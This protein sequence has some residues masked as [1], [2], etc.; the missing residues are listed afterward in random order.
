MFRRQTFIALAFSTGIATAILSPISVEA[1]SA[2]NSQKETAKELFTAGM[3]HY[4]AGDYKAARTSLRLVDGLQLPRKE[5]LVYYQTLE[6]VERQLLKPASKPAVTKAAPKPKKVTRKIVTK[7]TVVAKKATPKKVAPKK[8]PVRVVAPAP[9][10][11]NTR[12]II[13]HAKK[14]RVQEL[15]AEAAML[16]GKGENAAA[17]SRYKQVLTLD[18]KNKTAINMIAEIETEITDASES[19]I[20]V[21]KRNQSVQRG[22]VKAQFQTYLAIAEEKK[23]LKDY[24]GALNNVNQALIVLENN[25]NVFE[26]HSTN[27]WMPTAD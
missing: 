16:S 20:G 24:A 21:H 11:T 12:D 14:I 22:K 5:R 27:K 19:L 15:L 7:K 4:K 8:A 23:A 2:F 26:N 13:A 9:V 6:A 17:K 1:R 10:K 18:K 3:K 25:Q